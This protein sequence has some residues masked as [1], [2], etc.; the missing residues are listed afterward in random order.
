MTVTAEQA[1]RFTVGEVA[2]DHYLSEKR[3][4]RRANTVYGYESFIRL[5]VLPCWGPL[6]VFR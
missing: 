3:A 6:R 2:L 1:A 5:H 4:R